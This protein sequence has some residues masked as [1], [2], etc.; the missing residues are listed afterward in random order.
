MDASASK[1]C[2]KCGSADYTFRSRKKVAPEPGQQGPEQTETKYRCKKCEH[3]WRV[4]V[5]PAA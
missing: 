2:P 5:P 4:R 3:E 1:S